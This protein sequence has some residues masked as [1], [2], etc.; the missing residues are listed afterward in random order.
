MPKP[1]PHHRAKRVP[2]IETALQRRRLGG[3]DAFTV[4][5]RDMGGA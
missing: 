2:F 3:S 1:Q 5:G 4:A